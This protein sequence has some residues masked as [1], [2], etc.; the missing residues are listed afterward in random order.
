MPGAY[1]E[2][3]MVFVS[4]NAAEHALLDACTLMFALKGSQKPFKAEIVR[5]V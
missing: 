2:F 5:R 4:N 1:V 3:G